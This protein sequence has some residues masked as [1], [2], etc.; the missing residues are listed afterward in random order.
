M[1]SVSVESEQSQENEKIKTVSFHKL[2][3]FADISD[4]ALMIIGTLGAL[5]IG[6]SMPLMAIIFGDLVDS[7]GKN[8]NNTDIVDVVVVGKFVQLISAFIGGFSIAFARGWLLT[9]VLLT[10]I[11]PI[12]IAGAVTGL[13]I[14]KMASRGQ[15]A[16]AKAVAVVERTI[17]SI[18][19]VASFTGEKKA[20]SNY[21]KFLV[22]AYKSGVHEGLAAG[23]GV[24][25]IMFILFSSYALAIWYDGKFIMDQGYTGGKVFN[26]I[27]AVLGG[28]MSPGQASPCL[29]VFGAGQAATFKMFKTINRKPE[30]D[31]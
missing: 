26:V 12:A 17:G 11:P 3:T 4:V 8:Q 6:V 15:S 18:R 7:F 29:S 24:G 20:I 23:L 14:A 13:T 10:Y 30:I 21:N 28:S 1:Q 9:L 19:V 5:N 31:A 16:Y 27:I 2:F 25:L 22:S